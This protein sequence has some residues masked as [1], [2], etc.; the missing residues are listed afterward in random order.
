VRAL[1]FASMDKITTK[2]SYANGAK[3]NY[4]NYL[5]LCFLHQKLK[6]EFKLENILKFSHIIKSNI[7]FYKC[8]KYE[9]ILLT[10]GPSKEM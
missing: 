10:F 8:S 2:C 9:I 4:N 5:I 6:K 1:D 3:S 7:L